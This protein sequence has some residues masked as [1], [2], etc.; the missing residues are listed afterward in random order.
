MKVRY[1]ITETE[2]ITAHRILGKYHYTVLLV[3]IL[4]LLAIAF[5]SRPD[6]PELVFPLAL[7][8]LVAL[9]C[10]LLAE[11]YLIP[12]RCRKKYH[13]QRMEYDEINLEMT[14]DVLFFKSSQSDTT[15]FIY[16]DYLWS[17]FLTDD[18]LIVSAYIGY[19]DA[20]PAYTTY[21]DIV[22][23]IVPKRIGK[24]SFEQLIAR[25]KKSCWVISFFKS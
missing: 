16:F 21:Q 10:F 8:I 24:G 4:F 2:Y 13:Q 18:L 15:V 3:G 14:D 25:V 19:Q 1:Y 5:F 11:K 22:L 23:V 17:C 7:G 12:T 20:V 6:A 9:L